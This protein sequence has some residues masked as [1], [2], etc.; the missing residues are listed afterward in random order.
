MS[1]NNRAAKKQLDKAK[2]MLGIS[3]ERAEELFDDSAS[4]KSKDKSQKEEE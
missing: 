4:H 2:D 1:K 3:D